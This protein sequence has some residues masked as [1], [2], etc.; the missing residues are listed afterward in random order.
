MGGRTGWLIAFLTRA[1]P[2]RR[3]SGWAL[4]LDTAI[5]V[6]IAAAA[7]I[8]V[9]QQIKVARIVLPGVE[10]K[11]STP[12]PVPNWLLI[13]AA[14]SALPLALRRVLPITSLGAIVA[15]IL[16]I[17]TVQVPM[18]SLGTAV[19]AAYSA[20]VHS[21]YRNLAI[22]AILGSAITVTAV[23]EDALPR[24]PGRFSAM[25]AMV[26]VAA[27]GLGIR[28]LR[29][30]LADSAQRLHQ[31]TAE[32]AEQTQRALDTERARIAAELHDVVTHN[33]SVMVVQAGAARKVLTSSPAEAETVLAV[34]EGMLAV[35][36]SGR[37]AL[38]ELRHLLGLLGSDE[39]AGPLRP[40]PGL[41]DVAALVERVRGTGLQVHLEVHG[42][43]RALSAGPDL[44]G[45]R[46]VQEGLTNV[47]RH[48]GGETTSV[49]IKWGEELVITVSDDGV[50][51]GGGAGRGLTGLRERLAVYGGS[52]DAGPAPDHGGWLLRAVLPG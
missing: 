48:S 27:A 25:L 4:A 20:V 36:A 3:P 15:A 46:V 2:R 5:A 42:T 34:A 35:E 29:L 30:R 24:F 38:T 33:V 41:G 8:D 9:S 51:S 31:A 17:H 11:Y 44:A 45:Y 39:S 47:I 28:E 10:F 18:V 43:P 50:S 40:Q 22:A 37:T 7:V 6:G 21:K 14:L 1:E 19:F 52:L 26:P 49:V 12:A 13:G 16:A 23:L 32:H